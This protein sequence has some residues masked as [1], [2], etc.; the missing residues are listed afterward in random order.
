MLPDGGQPQSLGKQGDQLLRRYPQGVP[1][2]SLRSRS[3]VGAQKLP[4]AGGPSFRASDSALA[5][6]LASRSLES[7]RHHFGSPTVRLR[8][9]PNFETSWILTEGRSSEGRGH[10]EARLEPQGTHQRA[11]RATKR[12]TS[13]SDHP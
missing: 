1:P 5:A 8:H 3:P 13:A 7:S 4:P 10:V 2:L 12:G 6:G 11:L 9:I